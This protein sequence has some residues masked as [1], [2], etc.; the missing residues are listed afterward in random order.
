VEISGLLAP[1]PGAGIAIGPG[2]TPVEPV[3]R[4]PRWL[5][6]RV[7]IAALS[8][9]LKVPLAARV[10]RLDPALELGYARDLELLPNTLPPERHRGYA[11]QWFGLAFAT[12]VAALFVTLRPPK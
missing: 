5:L 12:L 8:K 3:G 6:T 10:L 11:L 2:Y 9:E 7:D 1:P 4:E